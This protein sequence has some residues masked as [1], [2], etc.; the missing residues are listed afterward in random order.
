MHMYIFIHSIDV[1]VYI[2]INEFVYIYVNTYIFLHIYAYI[3]IGRWIDSQ[4]ARHIQKY[5]D[6]EYIDISRDI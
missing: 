6:I 2:C 3:H 5:M 4:N 1:H